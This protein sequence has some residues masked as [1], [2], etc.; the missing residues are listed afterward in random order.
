MTFLQE[1]TDLLNQFSG[2]LQAFAPRA[3]EFCNGTI[4]DGA[5][6]ITLA[7]ISNT[8]GRY[9]CTTATLVR[10]VRSWFSCSTWYPLYQKVVHDTLCYGATDGF[11]FIATSQFFVVLAAI[12]V[13]TF[14]AALFDIEI[15]EE[16][17]DLLLTE[18]EDV[19]EIETGA[20]A[21]IIDEKAESKDNNTSKNNTPCTSLCTGTYTQTVSQ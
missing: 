19:K 20:Q 10:E 9:M 5:A 21:V 15:M 6:A 11:S 1:G 3:Q 16:N 17:D 13:L 8:T 14:R 2:Q 12:V 7:G 18:E 4:A